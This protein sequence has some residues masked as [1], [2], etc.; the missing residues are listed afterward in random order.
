MPA[1]HVRALAA[2]S[3]TVER[4]YFLPPSWLLL[5][6]D[7]RVEVFELPLGSA[8]ELRGTLRDS[9]LRG[10]S[11]AALRTMGGYEP[12][13]LRLTESLRD[14]GPVRLD[15]AALLRGTGYEQLFLELTAQCNERCSHCYA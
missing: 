2:V 9:V 12:A 10:E 4:A 7:E 5:D 6:D 1:S 15:R 14:H 13:L 8:V 11:S 3:G